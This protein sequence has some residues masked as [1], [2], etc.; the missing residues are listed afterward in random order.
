MKEI[1]ERSDEMQSHIESLVTIIK[2]AEVRREQLCDKMVSLAKSAKEARK[3]RMKLRRE[4]Y[5]LEKLIRENTYRANLEEVECCIEYVN[6]INENM[7]VT[8]GGN[9]N[10]I[11]LQ[12][13]KSR[14]P[15]KSAPSVLQ[16][17]VKSFSNISHKPCGG[18]VRIVH[19]KFDYSNVQAKVNTW[20]NTA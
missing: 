3:R 8:E 6:S 18:N 4:I 20:R 13:T 19:R 17:K 12:K 7:A 15:V 1:D 2:A 5:S 10:S 11:E 16:S 9:E 14:I